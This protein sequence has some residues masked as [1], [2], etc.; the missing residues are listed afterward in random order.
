MQTKYDELKTKYDALEAKYNA[1]DTRIKALEDA[2]NNEG[3]E[4]P[5]PENPTN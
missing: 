5:E 4:T 1:L 2:N 3:G